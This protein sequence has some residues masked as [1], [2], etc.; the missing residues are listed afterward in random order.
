[1]IRGL[2]LSAPNPTG[3]LG[4]KEELNQ[5]PVVNDL[6]SHTC[7]EASIKNPRG[8]GSEICMVGEHVKRGE[9]Q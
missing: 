1:M 4:K 3:T 8:W 9:G 6:V 2:G 5:S 7:H